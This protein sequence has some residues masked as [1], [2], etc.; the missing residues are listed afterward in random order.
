MAIAVN[1]SQELARFTPCGHYACVIR[2]RDLP[3][4][5]QCALCSNVYRSRNIIRALIGKS[6]FY[7]IMYD[8]DHPYYG[9]NQP[10]RVRCN[11]RCYPTPLLGDPHARYQGTQYACDQEF[12]ATFRELEDNTSPHNRQDSS[13]LLHCRSGHIL[14]DQLSSSLYKVMIALEICTKHRFDYPIP[15]IGGIRAAY[16]R[17][18]NIIIL[19]DSEEVMRAQHEQIVAVLSQTIGAANIPRIIHIDHHQIRQ[20]WGAEQCK[21]Y[22]ATHLPIMAMI[23]R[24]VTSIAGAVHP[25]FRQ[26]QEEYYL[27]KICQIFDSWRLFSNFSR[28]NISTLNENPIMKRFLTTQW[29][30]RVVMNP[31]EDP[32]LQCTLDRRYY[33]EDYQ[34]RV[35]MGEVEQQPQRKPRKKDQPFFRYNPPS[36]YRDDPAQK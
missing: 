4:M 2:S 17:K 8:D 12:F 25:E 20:I 18:F 36:M 23:T 24:I 32:P 27:Q 10:L 35:A 14:V 3:D 7:S 19:C 33:L 6:P 1:I 22:S 16:N 28:R 31:Y 29:T 11:G 5:Q 21:I 15:I 13:P 30:N 26:N 9:A 34:R